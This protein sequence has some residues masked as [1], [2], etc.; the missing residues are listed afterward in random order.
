M[1][2]IFY[3]IITIILLLCNIPLLF[4]AIIVAIWRWDTEPFHAFANGV[5][6]SE[7]GK[8]ITKGWD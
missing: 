6:D 4:L 7:L 8:Y 1:R 5:Y 2:Y 3:V